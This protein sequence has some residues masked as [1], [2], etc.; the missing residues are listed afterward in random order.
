MIDIDGSRGEGGGQVLRTS[1]AL[2]VMLG[3]PLRMRKVR[4]G[5]PKPGLARQHLAAVRAAAEISRAD[6]EG[7]SV[8]STSLR[9]TPTQPA[10]GARYLFDIGTAGSST[11]VFQTVLAPLLRASAPSELAL[12]GGTHNPMA[13]PF[14]F[15][16][17]VFLP[18]LGVDV[19]P[20][21]AR[22]GLYPKGGGA[23]DALVSPSRARSIALLDRG[24]LVSH[25]AT[26]V[27]AGLDAAI[28]EREAKAYRALQPDAETDVVVA[29]ETGPGNVV[30]AEL[31]FEHSRELVTLFGSKGVPA[32]RVAADLSR[33]VRAFLSSG[34]AVGEHLADQ[35]LL[36][37][38]FGEGAAF[39]TTELSLH[40]TTQ[41]ELLQEITG[42]RITTKQDGATVVVEAQ[43]LRHS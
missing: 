42:A 31:V 36:P 35:L 30:M 17:R 23:F 27:V 19:V 10:C 29:R 6:V 3:R 41:I 25:R 7:A 12:R 16:E 21:L 8:G 15:I 11:L 28:A 2:S 13:P 24:A 4:H 14:D 32:E 34:A 26:F 18:T 20:S 37:A 22:H 33:D 43:P 38:I 40:T 9:F 5:R 1:L 39:R